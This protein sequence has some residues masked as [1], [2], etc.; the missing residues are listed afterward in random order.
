MENIHS[1]DA[2]GKK[3]AVGALR[4]RVLGH[5]ER[6]HGSREPHVS[7][8]PDEY[9]DGSKFAEPV[10]DP[11]AEARKAA[12]GESGQ[13][14][15]PG[16]VWSPSEHGDVEVEKEKTVKEQ[17]KDIK[18]SEK[19]T[20]VVAASLNLLEPWEGQYPNAAKLPV[21]TWKRKPTDADGRAFV[22]KPGRC[23]GG[24]GWAAKGR[25][26]EAKLTD[27]GRSGWQRLGNAGLRH[28]MNVRNMKAVHL[29][30]K[31]K[32][33]DIRGLLE[34]QGNELDEVAF[35]ATMALIR[36]EVEAAE[37]RFGGAA[38]VQ[39]AEMVGE[40]MDE[41]H[42]RDGGPPGNSD[43]QYRLPRIGSCPEL[44]DM[45]GD[46][47]GSA[48]D[49]GQVDGSNQAVHSTSVDDQMVDVAEELETAMAEEEEEDVSE[50][51]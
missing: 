30:R 7:N 6:I 18:R 15:G 19:G 43:R 46:S 45:A 41:H 2:R 10:K 50:E 49:A 27:W 11:E 48:D 36:Y 42:E 14:Q 38:L 26:L 44:A 20:R 12:K 23:F 25:N 37:Q 39:L 32:L 1:Q 5:R 24:Q 35:Q 34:H 8:D 47:S 31:N 22:G 13:T 4:D 40:C 29:C 3:P 33:L 28:E 21:W 9:A 51:E 17:R 16:V